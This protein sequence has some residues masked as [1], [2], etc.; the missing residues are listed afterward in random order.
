MFYEEIIQNGRLYC[1]TTP[2]GEWQEKQTPRAL[3]LKALLALS[4]EDREAVLGYFCRFC[5]EL[6]P[7]GGC[8]C[9]RDE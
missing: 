8:V 3:A 5:N 9:H 1:R 4:Q 2:D 7:K 6:H